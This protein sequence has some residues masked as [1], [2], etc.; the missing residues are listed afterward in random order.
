DA[1][2][3]RAFRS[4]ALLVVGEARPAG[5]RHVRRRSPAGAAEPPDDPRDLGPDPPEGL[6]DAGAW[7]DARHRDAGR[8]AGATCDTVARP[9]RDRAPARPA[10][11]WRRSERGGRL[12]PARAHSRLDFRASGQPVGRAGPPGA[13]RSRSRL[14]RKSTRLNS[15]HDQISYAVFCLKKKK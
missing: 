1:E 10:D 8:G 3:D 12:R 13:R 2:A 14:D 15:S 5:A 7:I 6:I 9:L 11:R 4:D